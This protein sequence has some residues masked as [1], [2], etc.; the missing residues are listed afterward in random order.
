MCGS[1]AVT[2][3][4]ITHS[5]NNEIPKPTSLP[6]PQNIYYDIQIQSII[7]SAPLYLNLRIKD[8]LHRV[9]FK[10]KCNIYF[11]CKKRIKVEYSFKYSLW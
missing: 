3:Y 5:S 6:E 7:H 10:Y 9:I 2:V 8:S 4:L 11:F 1:N